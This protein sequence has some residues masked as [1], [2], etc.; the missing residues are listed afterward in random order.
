MVKR[1]VL[2]P[3]DNNEILFILITR[4]GMVLTKKVTVSSNVT[5]DDLYCFSKYLTDEL[6]GYAINE[7]KDTHLRPPAERENAR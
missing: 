5:Q 3:M 1:V 7:I 4:T 2:V 6:C